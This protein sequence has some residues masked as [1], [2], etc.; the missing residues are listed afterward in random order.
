[1]AMSDTDKVVSTASYAKFN[2]D[3]LDGMLSSYDLLGKIFRKKSFS[4]LELDDK[5]SLENDWL[6]VGSDIG[7]VVNG[8]NG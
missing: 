6:I 1:M 5:A 8:F 3:F 7:Q 2:L 4:G